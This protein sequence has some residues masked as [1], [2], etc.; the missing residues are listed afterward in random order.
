M[1]NTRRQKALENRNSPS[2]RRNK[3]KRSKIPKLKTIP[4]NN[5]NMADQSTTTPSQTVTICENEETENRTDATNDGLTV[6]VENNQTLTP[7]ATN[8]IVTSLKDFFKDTMK[9]FQKT[10][11]DEFKKS[12][13]TFKNEIRGE[14]VKVNEKLDNYTKELREN[15]DD[16]KKELRQETTDQIK[17]VVEKFDSRIVAVETSITETNKVLTSGTQTQPENI[18][19]LE[20]EIENLK[21]TTGLNQLPLL[22][23][24]VK[25][26]L[27][28]F[29]NNDKGFPKEFLEELDTWF[30][31]W[32]VIPQDKLR[33]LKSSSGIFLANAKFWF[34]ATKTRLETY[35]QF[36]DEFLRA[37][38]D[39]PTRLRKRAEWANRRFTRGGPFSLTE[40][41]YDQMHRGTQVDEKM[42]KFEIIYNVI[43]Q[44][45]PEV[46]Q[47]L[48][49]SVDCHNMNS[50]LEKL[51]L[52]ENPMLF[53][54]PEYNW[55]YIPTI[56]LP[57]QNVS[58]VPAQFHP[59]PQEK[60]PNNG[61]KPTYNPIKIPSKPMAPNTFSSQAQASSSQNGNQNLN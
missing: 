17:T 25:E 48:I 8:V 37:H 41:F 45:P 27:P 55:G 46:V 20:A 23:S 11:K 38:W 1:V 31:K 32:G 10:I 3:N 12:Q 58:S 13:N 19:K 54:Y 59:K 35:E 14:F 18:K 33:E 26:K 44:F 42:T 7:D 9:D 36:K 21:A 57:G 2:P 52:M 50:V 16:A 22:K 47:I 60:V 53:D 29:T 15:I 61:N 39:E 6:T 30:K 4:E 24:L 49:G 43:R 28:S 5:E 56:Q 51:G 34:E 40:Y